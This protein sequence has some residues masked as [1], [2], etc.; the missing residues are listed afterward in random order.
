MIRDFKKEDSNQVMKIWLE[1]NRKTHSFIEQEYW[2]KN[3]K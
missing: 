2:K 1:T 3:E